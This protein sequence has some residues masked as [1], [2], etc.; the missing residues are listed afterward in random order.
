MH[1][2]YYTSQDEPGINS[3]W[4]V[5]YDTYLR[6]SDDEPILGMTAWVRTELTESMA[7]AVAK[8]LQ[9]E[10]DAKR[11]GRHRAHRADRFAHP[12]YRRSHRYFGA[13]SVDEYLPKH[14][15]ILTPGP[16]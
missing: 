9:A 12:A 8:R 15:P 6:V 5:Y 1:R 14:H 2:S 11:V 3:T 16:R 7:E 10:Y 4:S 13:P